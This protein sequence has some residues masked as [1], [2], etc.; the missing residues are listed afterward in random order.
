MLCKNFDEKTTA[1]RHDTMCYHL[2]DY[3]DFLPESAKCGLFLY[4][5]KW[6]RRHAAGHQHS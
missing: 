1:Y 2:I 4:F 3:I 6:T 5:Y